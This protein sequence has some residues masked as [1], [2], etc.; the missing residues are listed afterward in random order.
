MYS[1]AKKLLLVTF[2][3]AGFAMFVNEAEARCP[4]ASR[5]HCGRGTTVKAKRYRYYDRYRRTYTT[6][7]RFVCEA[8]R[9]RCPRAYYPRCSYGKRPYKTYYSYRGYRCMRWKCPRIVRRRPSKRVFAWANRTF[10]VFK[11]Y[12]YKKMCWNARARAHSMCRGYPRRIS[13]VFPGLP[14]NL[15]AALK[16]GNRWFFFKG[17][18]YWMYYLSRG[19]LYKGNGYPALVSSRFKPLRRVDGATYANGYW[20]LFVGGSYYKY[21]NR[22]YTVMRGY[23]KRTSTI[24]RG[25]PYMGG[26]SVTYAA[27]NWWFI[28]GNRFWVFR[29][30]RWLP[31][32]PKILSTRFRGAY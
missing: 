16:S 1:A 17:N 8:R 31:G 3:F 26:G 20:Y 2:A 13:N 23:P 11:G 32:Y 28:K 14:G 9:S 6:C 30:T 19:K 27:G 21:P 22:R 24:F 15:D 4:R 29:G 10:Y 18:R 7:Y 5:P 12:T 25:V